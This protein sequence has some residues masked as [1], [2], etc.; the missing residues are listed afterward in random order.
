MTQA[1]AGQK[2]I[3]VGGTSG[4]GKAVAQLILQQGGAAVL[5]GSR[6]PKLEE[7]VTELSHYGTV[8]GEL[9]NISDPEMRNALIDRLNVNHSDATL[10]VNAAGVFLPK[11]FIEYEE[12][13]YDL[14]LDIN[15]GTFFITQG[16]V[17]NM[18]KNG[19]AGA[20]VNIGSMWAKQAIEATP[21]SAYS[22]A[23]AGLHSL[24][25]HLAME[26]ANY[27]IRVNAVSPAVV[28]TPIYQ[29]FIPKEQVHSALEGFNSFHP[30]GR[31]GKPTDIAEA[32]VYLLSEKASWVTGAVWDVDG[33]VMAGRNQY[34]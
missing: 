8:V 5:I 6:Q 7:A 31:V 32:V 11:P 1:F 33:G 10:L 4:M 22:M 15:K 34:N 17:K 2:I 19:K 23:K 12:K 16:I 24:T 20:I 18:I 30:I 3:V 26:L 14:Y 28:E 13:D 29:G 25:Q 27:N 21:S 9:A